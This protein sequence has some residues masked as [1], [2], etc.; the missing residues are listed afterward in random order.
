[1]NIVFRMRPM[2]TLFLVVLVGVLIGQFCLHV[3]ARHRANSRRVKKEDPFKGTKCPYGIPNTG[4]LQRCVYHTGY[5]L[6]LKSEK[7]DCCKEARQDCPQ[8]YC[9]TPGFAP[10]NPP[11]AWCKKYIIKDWKPIVDNMFDG[12]DEPDMN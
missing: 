7:L 8:L 9:S 4:E 6:P 5:G 2:P 10:C 12:P 11:A 1:M 3:T